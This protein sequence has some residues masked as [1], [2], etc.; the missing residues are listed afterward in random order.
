MKWNM[1]PESSLCIR[2]LLL[3]RLTLG[4][5]LSGKKPGPQIVPITY[6]KA[7]SAERIRKIIW[8]IIPPTD[9]FGGHHIPFMYIVVNVTHLIIPAMGLKK[10]QWK[11]RKRRKKQ[12]QQQH[13]SYEI[14]WNVWKIGGNL[15]KPIC[16]Y[17]WARA[18]NDLQN[19]SAFSFC[20]LPPKTGACRRRRFF[21]PNTKNEWIDFYFIIDMSELVCA[22]VSFV[23][24][25]EYFL[26]VTKYRK[27][28][29][30]QY[31]PQ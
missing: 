18:N 15:S 29:F 26:F 30:V 2:T 10:P 16:M 21:V 9:R 20:K 31:W 8:C 12:Q 25:I 14:E 1:K 3:K 22:C 23:I 24:T 4:S 11:E 6:E 5:H 28:G 7:A 17:K 27:N 13:E 19:D